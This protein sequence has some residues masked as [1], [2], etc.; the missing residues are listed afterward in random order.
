[1]AR[2]REFRVTLS[3]ADAAKLSE[4]LG[5]ELQAFEAEQEAARR[6]QRDRKRRLARGLLLV[7]LIGALL[8]VSLANDWWQIGFTW[9]KSLA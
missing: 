8:W 3:A 7:M 4:L 5:D 1:M 2:D 9:I 6:R